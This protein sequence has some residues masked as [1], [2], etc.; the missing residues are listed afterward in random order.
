MF[1]LAWFTN[2][3]AHGWTANGADRWAGNDIYPERWQTLSFL[4]DFN[5]LA[6]AEFAGFENYSPTHGLEKNAVRSSHSRIARSRKPALDAQPIA[7]KQ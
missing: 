7:T 3:R 6:P 1:H 5:F 2:P 4:K